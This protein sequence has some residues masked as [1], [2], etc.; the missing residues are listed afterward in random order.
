MD[1]FQGLPCKP[2]LSQHL[3]HVHVNHIEIMF[4]Q[5]GQH[6]VKVNVKHA[7]QILS[8]PGIA[9]LEQ[10]KVMRIAQDGLVQCSDPADGENTALAPVPALFGKSAKLPWQHKRIDVPVHFIDDQECRVVGAVQD[11][12]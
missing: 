3:G 10:D 5:C 2:E 9:D 1:C 7:L 8:I 6:P 12:Y 11:T 4:S